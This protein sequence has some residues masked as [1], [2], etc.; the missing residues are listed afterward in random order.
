M[1]NAPSMVLHDMSGGQY[2]SGNFCYSI[3]L[4]S[5]IAETSL[6]LGNEQHFLGSAGKFYFGICVVSWYF[7]GVKKV[8]A[9]KTCMSVDGNQLP[10]MN[11]YNRS[12]SGFLE[13]TCMLFTTSTV[14]I[15]VFCVINARCIRMAIIR[16]HGRIAEILCFPV[17][18]LDWK[19]VNY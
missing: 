4:H 5:F 14:Q 18:V 7:K 2:N 16:L 17:V 19:S 9:W 10:A 3:L 12:F 11:D 1:G 15:T 6:P 8:S 13:A